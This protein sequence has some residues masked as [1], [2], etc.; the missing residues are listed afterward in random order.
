MT[1]SLVFNHRTLCEL[2]RD[3]QS[4]VG[5]LRIVHHFE[6]AWRAAGPTTREKH[7]FEAMRHVCAI[8]DMEG[9]R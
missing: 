7:Y 3:L 4:V 9:Q 2:Q 1:E 5:D 6:D 8:P